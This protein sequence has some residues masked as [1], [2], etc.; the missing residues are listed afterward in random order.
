MTNGTLI[1]FG[2]QPGTGK[3]TLASHLAERTGAVWLRCID[4]VAG[5]MRRNAGLVA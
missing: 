5:A 1:D 4:E 3:S 2:G